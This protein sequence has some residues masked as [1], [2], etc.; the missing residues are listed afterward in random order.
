MNTFGRFFRFTT[1]G[2]SHGRALGV[3]V[4]GCPPGIEFSEADMI[5]LL[6]RRRPGLSPL[7]TPRSESDNP[8]I[9]SG[10]FEGKT[11]GMPVAMIV[12]NRDAR[13]GDYESGKELFRPGHADY[14]YREKYGI[15]DYRGG[16][17]SSGRETVSR[18]MAGALAMKMLSITG[19]SFKS[20]ILSVHGISDPGL[21]EDEIL[22]AKS[23]GDSV[24]GVA[25]VTVKGCPAGVGDPVF[26]RLD[27][28]LSAAMMSVGAVKGVEIGDGFSSA[29]VFG[30]ENN[31][32]MASDEYGNVKF[33]SNHSGG[34]LGGIS[35]GE[36]IVIRIAVKPTP[37]I[38]SEQQ[39]VDIHGN[40]RLISTGGRH[41]PC[42]V[43][44]ITVVAEAMAAV[45]IADSYL[46][47][48]AYAPFE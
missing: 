19:I 9:L 21:F 43:P 22:S 13:S 28:A 46:S 45:V 38:S 17:R 7:S 26:G 30:S 39:T 10:I 2:E 23:A 47:M 20:R 41:D 44:R 11:T 16:G 42:I 3:V 18:V 33:L 14:T 35:T 29:E 25:E 34:I 15:R 36:D 24:G 32:S 5:P 27:A 31:D 40:N 48:R 12:R 4:D 6:E 8:E 1:F 37:S